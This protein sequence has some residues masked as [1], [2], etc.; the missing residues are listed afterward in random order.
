[1]CENIVIIQ[2]VVTRISFD[3]DSIAHRAHVSEYK[4]AKDYSTL[5]HKLNPSVTVY[6]DTHTTSTL[7]QAQPTKELNFK[8]SPR[9]QRTRKKD[10]P[11]SLATYP[12][13]I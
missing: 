8:M 13:A 1:V 3:I 5:N 6:F 7:T 12:G 9:L 10:N 4:I 11:L 2:C